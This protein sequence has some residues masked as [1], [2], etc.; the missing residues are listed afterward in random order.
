MTVDSSAPSSS[1]RIASFAPREADAANDASSRSANRGKR[2]GTG[3]AFLGGAIGRLLPASIPFRYFGAAVVFHVLAW[4]AL[5]AGADGAARFRGGLGWPLAALHLVTLGVLVMTALGASLQLLPVATRQSVSSRHA[6]ALIWWLY[7]PGVAATALGMGVASV[8]LLAAGALL[9]AVALAIYAVVLAANLFGARGMPAVVAHGW[10]AWVS[11]AAAL[12]AA[13]S[14]AL[15]YVGGP[16]LPRGVAL[17]L[18]VPFAGYGF[19]GMLALGLSYIVVPMFA[20]SHAPDERRA[21]AS[22]ALAVVALILAALAGFGVTVVG[23]RV[24]AVVAGSAAVALHLRLMVTALRTGM[25][26]D[27]GP[28]FRLVRIGWG[29]L[30]ASLV[31]ALGVALDVPFDGMGTLFGFTL[32]VGW[33]L[34]FLLGILQRI[35]PFLAS[36]HAARGRHLPPTPS[37]LGAG[38]SLRIHY[39]GHLAALV[40]LALAI[41]VDS[42]W[43]VRAGAAAGFVGAGAFL[44][45][46]ATVVR[47]ML[48]ANRAA[49][50]HGV[51][52]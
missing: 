14:L 48:E 44:L 16:A 43:L 12:I 27:L 23:A 31:A 38:S 21:L 15:A 36:M 17:T 24:G 29:M 46:F 37:S 49:K 28:S 26:H 4:A 47:R 18:H 7:T 20:L 2:K 8:T 39:I 35:V 3:A 32:I 5:A 11:L 51:S 10:V 6:P 40:L 9:V 25:R 13:L 52:A 22:C 1:P 34:T 50:A 45:F 19:M 33:L 42:P 41:A 30:V